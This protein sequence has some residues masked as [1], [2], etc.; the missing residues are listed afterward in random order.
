MPDR[1]ADH[2]NNAP[3][4]IVFMGS[5]DFAVPALSAL[6]RA[7]HEIVCV[8][9]QPPRPAGRG[10]KE[11]PCPVH[12]FALENGLGV[13]T[14]ASLKDEAEQRAF[15]QLNADIAVVAAYGLILPGAV[16]AAP[17][18]GCV[19][20][21]ASLLP[22]W[23]G[24]AP[25]QRAIE[26]GDTETG[27]SIMAMEAGLDTG[28]VYMTSTL[29]I[30]TN[31]TAQML[32]DQLALLGAAMIADAVREIAAGAVSPKPQAETGVTYAAKIG[33]GDGRL[34]WALS[35][36]QLAR[37]VRALNPWPGVWCEQAGKRLKVLAAEAVEGSGA[38]GE[39]I[40]APLTVACGEGALRIIRAQ[41][42]GKAAMDADELVRGHAIALGSLLD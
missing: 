9:T 27:I 7:G 39:V 34:D 30:T 11:R 24:A 8:Y 16:L 19:N 38:A 15:A 10:Q 35:A 40:A 33:P 21:H 25:I 32:H 13:R 1:I 2:V 22:R 37:K 36:D 4:R 14:P 17:R 5:P 3:L 31:T 12:A 28:P 6:I 18:F 20:I 26:A 41:R 42:A 29:S 23:R